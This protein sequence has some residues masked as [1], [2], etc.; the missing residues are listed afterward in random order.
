M[1]I[2]N[3]GMEIQ[4]L[5]QWCKENYATNQKQH[6]HACKM[7]Q[8]KKVAEHSKILAVTE[9]KD[10]KEIKIVYTENK[11]R[12]TIKINSHDASHVNQQ[13]KAHSF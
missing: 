9:M 11:L 13:A 2:Q 12:L 7:Q 1:Q 8:I 3:I 10:W 4:L 5:M 6:I